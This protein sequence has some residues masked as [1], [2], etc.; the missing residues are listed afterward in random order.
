MTDDNR[1]ASHPE[2]QARQG[3]DPLL[4]LTRLFNLDFNADGN[5]PAHSATSQNANNRPQSGGPDDVDLSFLEN[6]PQEQSTLENTRQEQTTQNA[7]Y[8]PADSVSEP[9]NSDSDLDFLPNDV[10]SQSTPR[11]QEPSLPFNELYDLPS[12]TPQARSSG[13][14][15]ETP[16]GF[17]NEQLDTS[18]NI[19]IGDEPDFPVDA[20]NQNYNIAQHEQIPEDFNFVPEQ[21]ETAPQAQNITASPVTPSNQRSNFTEA[22]PHNSAVLTEPV[23]YAHSD[24]SSLPTQEIAPEQQY[25]A[26]DEMLFDKELENLLVNSPLAG[27][28]ETN[29][30][31]HGREN[32][33]PTNSNK[34]AHPQQQQANQY[35][36]NAPSFVDQPQAFNPA[37]P[38][39]NQTSQSNPNMV[40]QAADSANFGYADQ[41]RNNSAPLPYSPPVSRQTGDDLDFLNGN[42]PLTDDD[43]YP[44]SQQP[45]N[46]PDANRAPEP[47]AVATP[48]TGNTA[49]PFGLED[50]STE[51]N[52]I[53]NPPVYPNDLD[54]NGQSNSYE[55]TEDNSAALP[56][57]AQEFEQQLKPDVHSQQDLQQNYVQTPQ[58]EPIEQSVPPE[59]HNDYAYDTS[60]DTQNEANGQNATG[61]NANVPPDVDTYKFADEIVETTEPVDV[62][63]IPYPTEET[64]QKG[65]AL[66]NE[67]AD[68]F[69]V[70]NKQQAANNPTEQDEFF[71]DA[72]A[73]SGY[74]LK[75][76]QSQSVDDNNGVKSDYEIDDPYNAYADNGQTVLTENAALA[77][78]QNQQRPKSLARKLMFGGFALFIVLGGGYAA[79]KY[80][81]PSQ[82]NGTSTV[83]HADNEPF[84]VPAEQKDTNSDTQNNQEVYNHASGADDAVKDNQDKLVDRSE[85]PEDLTALNNT[86]EGVDS[87]TDPSNVEDAIAAASNQSVPTREV[88]SVVVNPDGTISPSAST[89]KSPNTDNIENGN[90]SQMKPVEEAN[91]SQNAATKT[92]TNANTQSEANTSTADSELTK[93]I[94]D[95]AQTNAE[96]EN[97]LSAA[98]A[99]NQNSMNGLNSVTTP[100]VKQQAQPVQTADVPL[101]KPA[102]LPS[103]TATPETT[104]NPKSET[105]AP[106]ASVGAGGY[107]VQIASQPTRESAVASLNNA[108]SSLGALLGSLPLSIE[109]ASIP[110][111]GTYY[112]VRVQVGPRDNA[113]SLCERIK[114]KKGNCF[115]GK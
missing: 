92:S 102:N 69:S 30:P 70:G 74:K 36:V 12:F 64:T 49:D 17:E 39:Y 93:I 56:V 66:E 7:G 80:F 90:G 100:T 31:L 113:I 27:D 68:V 91:A 55:T 24:Q 101:Q 32:F 23:H 96:K 106:M 67:Y 111:K 29:A 84:K 109:P 105:P 85:N 114:S 76:N 19:P 60:F 54:R 107:Y 58:T 43:V 59:H 21:N 50:L 18:P 73:Q 112:R 81:M 41:T 75:Q 33:T 1:N 110:G 61:Q 65:D 10:Q 44:N 98:A 77:D 13:T 22:A 95:D 52:V 38:A 3:R 78:L 11:A 14:P 104:N 72:Y 89:I 48:S 15:V 53:V 62:P 108:K 8:Q 9:Q 63:E 28:D 26:F 57:E 20:V 99:T 37:T 45:E 87:Y 16:P 82:E 83:I 42:D 47:A 6:T 115:V 35:A 34:N 2:G 40:A 5:S 103:K 79:I 94:N 25:P 97:S 88:Q 46:S 4:E 86:P 51:E 71:A